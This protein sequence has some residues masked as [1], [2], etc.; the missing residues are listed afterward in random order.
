[1]EVEP[2]VDP[3]AQFWV[4]AVAENW[5]TCW[6]LLGDDTPVYSFREDEDGLRVGYVDV[7]FVAETLTFIVGKGNGGANLTFPDELTALRVEGAGCYEIE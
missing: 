3:R 2:E 5:E 1:M 4:D 6:P 7:E